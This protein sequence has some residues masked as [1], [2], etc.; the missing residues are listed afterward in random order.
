MKKLIPL[1]I[2]MACNPQQVTSSTQKTIENP[3]GIPDG[4]AFSTALIEAHEYDSSHCINGQSCAYSDVNTHR[5]LL[6]FDSNLEIDQTFLN[7]SGLKIQLTESPSIPE[8]GFDAAIS[9]A[10][11]FLCYQ[12]G[13]GPYNCGGS[14]FISFPDNS[15]LVAFREKCGV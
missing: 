9:R 1:F 4:V 5:Q 15:D 7:Q 14:Y 12:N 10:D 2:L 3:C 11:E 6:K 13:E 8:T